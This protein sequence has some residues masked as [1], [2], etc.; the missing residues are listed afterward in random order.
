[1]LV[2]PHDPVI[3]QGP[4]TG[5]EV[6]AARNRTPLPKAYTRLFWTWFAFGFPAFGAVSGISWLMFPWLELG[7]ALDCRSNG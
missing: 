6:A 3:R 4:A 1:L 7:I 5:P 2:A